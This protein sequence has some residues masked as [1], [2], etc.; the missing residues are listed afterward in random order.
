VL[1]GVL[2]GVPMRR[3]D[4]AFHIGHACF[5]IMKFINAAPQ[6]KFSSG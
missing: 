2:I 1:I 6:Q 5:H 3:S 4:A